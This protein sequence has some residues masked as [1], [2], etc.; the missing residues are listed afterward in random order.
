MELVI[1]VALLGWVLSAINN[2]A[3]KRTEQARRSAHA[4]PG[5]AP[6]RRAPARPTEMDRPARPAQPIVAP[7]LRRLN[8]LGGLRPRLL[9]LRQPRLDLGQ[10][11]VQ[12]GDILRHAAL[13]GF[14]ALLRRL[15]ACLCGRH[16]IHGIDLLALE[17]LRL[18][19]SVA[20]LGLH[21][22]ELLVGLEGHLL[23]LEL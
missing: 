15:D 6:I 12:L 9:Q 19:E 14:Q 18:V 8:L 17:G 10:P 7:E 23:L 22:P 13:L 11:A 4:S 16:G 21:R 1:I 20:D 3:K 2:G 5:E